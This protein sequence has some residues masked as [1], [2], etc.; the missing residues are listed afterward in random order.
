MRKFNKVIVTSLVALAIGC[1]SAF[2]VDAGSSSS[3]RSSFGSSSSF[4]SSFKSSPSFGGGSSYSKPSSTPSSV[5]SYSKPVIDKPVIAPTITTTPTG[6]S[7]PTTPSTI[8]TNGYTKPGTTQSTISSTPVLVAP[9][10][11]TT[12]A[13]KSMSSSSLKS[14]QADRANAKMPQ[15]PIDST[16]VKSDPAYIAARRTYGNVDDYMAQRTNY[17]NV[18]RTQ[19]PNI[20]VYSHNMYPYYGT[21]DN[22]FLLGM[23]FGY[24]GSNTASNAAWFYSHEN[25][26][27]YSQWRADLNRQ[28]QDNAELKSK[29]D[30]VD[31]EV[32]QLK[33]QG[34]APVVKPIPDGIDSSIAIAP[35]AMLAADS[36]N[37]SE[38]SWIPMIL[39]GIG[40]VT[41]ILVY[42]FIVGRRP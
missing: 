37:T 39:I 7:K 30:N 14:Y 18:Y 15:A 40:G 42:L 8:S 5:T 2:P 26:P 23:V 31:A 35:E 28:A 24:L 33:T 36:T 4:S 19:H 10:A 12:A 38:T 1:A 22:S 11:L 13:S 27:W 17:Y 32:A 34:T 3:G 25:D 9:S 20:V 29:L 21:Y 41:G 16:A 6:Y